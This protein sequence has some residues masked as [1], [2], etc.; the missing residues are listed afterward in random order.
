M[1]KIAIYSS[2]P[3]DICKKISEIGTGKKLYDVMPFFNGDIS[4]K[5]DDNKWD[6]NE[7]VSLGSNRYSGISEASLSKMS[8]DNDEKLYVKEIREIFIKLIEACSNV[9]LDFHLLMSHVVYQPN[10]DNVRGF[11]LDEKSDYLEIFNKVEVVE[12]Q[13]SLPFKKAT[14][15]PRILE[16]SNNTIIRPN[17]GDL[18]LFNRKKVAYSSPFSYEPFCNS[19]YERPECSLDNLEG[20]KKPSLV[21]IGVVKYKTPYVSSQ[22]LILV[23]VCA[24]VAYFLGKKS[25]KPSHNKVEQDIDT[26]TET[27]FK[28][29]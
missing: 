19:F 8:S 9:K 10:E 16:P 1:K 4:S 26:V 22:F 2:F 20:Y 21:L 3:E 15:Q 28:N 18:L 11:N 27:K 7:M 5:L 25:L 13:A 6:Y 24:M 17:L 12:I 14:M 29:N 23:A